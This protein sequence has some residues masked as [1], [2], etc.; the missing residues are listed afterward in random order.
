[1]WYEPVRRSLCNEM[2][3]LW[4]AGYPSLTLST[5]INPPGSFYS[6]RTIIH[7]HRG[8]PALIRRGHSLSEEEN[9]QLM[10]LLLSCWLLLVMDVTCV[11]TLSSESQPIKDDNLVLWDFFCT[12][13]D[14]LSCKYGAR[15][16]RLCVIYANDDM[17]DLLNLLNEQNLSEKH[18]S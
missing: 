3:T 9:K 1:M 11:I 18:T 2:R 8:G 4:K 7:K 17:F 15:W 12:P 14:G 6:F 5:Y 13:P 10:H 16:R